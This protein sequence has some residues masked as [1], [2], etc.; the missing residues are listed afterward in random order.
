MSP[1]LLIAAL[2]CAVVYGIYRVLKARA[3][4]S[5]T[6]P[7]PQPGATVTPAPTKY[8]PDKQKP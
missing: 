8:P 6:L 7:P 5:G 2:V 4:K 1:K 3:A